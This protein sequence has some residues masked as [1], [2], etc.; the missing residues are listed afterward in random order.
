[1]AAYA[2]YA[3]SPTTTILIATTM[4]EAFGIVPIPAIRSLL[5]LNVDEHQQ[6]TV[7][8]VVANVETLLQLIAPPAVGQ[9]YGHVGHRIPF[10]MLTGVA[11]AFIMLSAKLRATGAVAHSSISTH[12]SL[13]FG[14]SFTDLTSNSF[15]DEV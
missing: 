7:L 5:S 8:S 2:G 14:G 13:I 1:M 4:G 15:S 12:G 9:L 10:M 3:W 6:G 11:L